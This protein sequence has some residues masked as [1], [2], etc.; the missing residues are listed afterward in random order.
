M[1]RFS[2]PAPIVENLRRTETIFEVGFFAPLI[3]ARALPGQFIQM[4]P[5]EDLGPEFSRPFS[6]R[7]AQTDA[8]AIRCV[9]TPRGELTVRLS[10]QPVGSRVHITG[11]LGIGFTLHS[12]AARHVLVAGGLGASPLWFFGERAIETHSI[13][14]EQLAL[15]NGARGR[16]WLLRAESLETRAAS[17][18][19]CTEDGSV[20]RAGLV[21]PALKELLENDA[22][23]TA[24]YACGPWAML[25]AVAHIAADFGMRC[26]VSLDTAIPCGVGACGECEVRTLGTDG[27]ETR[28]CCVDGPVFD[29]R[30]VDWSAR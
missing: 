19:I 25:R 18:I 14:V 5:T 29:A 17:S 20:G 2:A 30:F 1:E 10:Q 6:I 24:V 12:D 9:C 7:S 26:Q 27:A 16:E 15:V 3:A 23:P 8:G 21:A 4:R 22:Q 11:P 28:L 13:G